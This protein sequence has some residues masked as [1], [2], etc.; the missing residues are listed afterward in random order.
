MGE[1][2]REFSYVGQIEA[3]K[4][5]MIRALICQSYDPEIQIM[6]DSQ[7]EDVQL[8]KRALRSLSEGQRM[9][10]GHA[11][12][13]LR[14]MALRAARQP[15]IHILSGSPRLFERPMDELL[16]ILRQLGCQVSLQGHELQVESWGWKMSGDALHV[17]G[18]RS[19]QFASGVVVNSWG[20]D[21]PVFAFLGS[22]MSS[23]SYFAMTCKLVEHFGMKLDRWGVDLRI[24]ARQSV[25]NKKYLCEPDMSSA[26]TIAAVAAVSG[27][28]VLTEMPE[29]SWQPDSHFV[30]FFLH[31]NIPIRWENGNLKIEKAHRLK[32]IHC[33]LGQTPDLFPILAA[34][35]ALAPGESHLY[36]ARQLL[37]KE[38]DRLKQSALL[39][40]LC[41]REVIVQDDGLK[42]HGK[43]SRALPDLVEYDPDQDHRMAMAAGVLK[44][45]GLP[46]RIKN[47]SVVSKSFPDFWKILGVSE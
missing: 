45:A 43:D 14:F 22:R 30:E 6:G 33:N 39:L 8:L 40:R 29:V 19:S 25:Q 23:S 9:E 17:P 10:C 20:L 12:A 32:P 21:F 41:G 24:P 28:A 36:G 1:P 11:G 26:S 13:V 7:A 15:G 27:R 18:D 16:K 47:A 2:M 3:S 37:F 5:L 4:S 38:S 34:L 44:M 31:M 46:I 42:I 35:C